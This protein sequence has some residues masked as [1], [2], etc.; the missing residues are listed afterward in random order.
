[1]TRYEASLLFLIHRCNVIM[2]LYKTKINKL[3]LRSIHIR[4]QRPFS[5]LFTKTKTN[6]DAY[7]VNRRSQSH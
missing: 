7:I 2:F 6:N 1:M 4:T 3:K 5:H